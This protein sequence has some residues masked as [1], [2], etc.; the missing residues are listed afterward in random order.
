[1]NSA[2]YVVTIDPTVNLA[3]D[4]FASLSLVRAINIASNITTGPTSLSAINMTRN[5]IALK[6]TI[7]TA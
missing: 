3:R 4:I 5:I 1:M 7:H 6:T 2:G